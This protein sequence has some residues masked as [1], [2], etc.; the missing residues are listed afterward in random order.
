MRRRR[1]FSGRPRGGALANAP[2]RGRPLSRE[3]RF[4]HRALWLLL[5]LRFR[6][7]LRRLSRSA[8]TVRGALFLVA[9]LFFFALV[10]GPNVVLHLMQAD[11]N[12]G[13]LA[14][15]EHTRRVGPLLLFAYCALT[16]L[17]ASA[18]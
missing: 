3:S 6:A 4:M 17:F 8:G 14:Y 2:P 18:E 1:S 5:W 15:V 16:V 12:G 7:W 13:P 10:I 11:R 9:G